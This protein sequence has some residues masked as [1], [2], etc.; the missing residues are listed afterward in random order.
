MENPDTETRI[1]S[2][3]VS[4]TV[5]ER[6]RGK[7]RPGRVLAVFDHACDLMIAGE[8]VVALV[9]PQVGA[10]PLNVV[11][12]GSPGLFRDIAPGMPATLT[13]RE[14]LV[15]GLVVSLKKAAVW[16]PRPDWAALRACRPVILNHLPDP[17]APCLERVPAES[18]IALL[19]TPPS[20]TF[21]R[22][23]TLAAAQQA[24]DALRAGWDGNPVRLCEGAEQMA[25]LG[26]GLT[27]SGDDFLTGVMLWAWLAHPVP[28]DL[29]R[30][31]TAAAA[32]HTTTLSAAFLR[33]AARGE[34]SIAWH[35]LLE[36]ASQGTNAQ[37]TQAI[38]N[39]LAHGATSG[40]D[41]LAGFMWAA[42]LSTLAAP[43]RSFPP[44]AE[45]R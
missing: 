26:N 11:V 43:Y 39:V 42:R 9:T 35:A 28:A 22:G 1:D 10:G 38:K 14:I 36:A 25:G 32:G 7:P 17:H 44:R 33:A 45:G 19:Q 13:D 31:V 34:C 18:L 15:G 16:E 23:S 21:P 37:V 12:R 29:C 20:E 41:A 30:A 6:L 5:L 24:L 4:R 3:I 8:R 40:A 2:L 27:P